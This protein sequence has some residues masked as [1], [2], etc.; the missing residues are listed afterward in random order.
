MSFDHGK[1]FKKDD[2]RQVLMGSYFF[3]GEIMHE[4]TRT[5]FDLFG[6]LSEFGGMQGIIIIIFEFM[7]VTNNDAKLVSKSVRSLFFRRGVS[8][9]EKLRF[10]FKHSL[11]EYPLTCFFKNRSKEARLFDVG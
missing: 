10:K 7:I 8:G 1:T 3:M 11:M 6:L 4:D 9:P 5:V 2:G